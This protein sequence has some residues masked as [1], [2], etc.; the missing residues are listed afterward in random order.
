MGAAAAAK[1]LCIAATH[2]PSRAGS[3]YLNHLID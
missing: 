1:R 2:A 3:V